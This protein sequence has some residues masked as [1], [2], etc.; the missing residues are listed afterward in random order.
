MNTIRIGT[1]GSKLALAQAYEI[2]DRLLAAHEGLAPEAIEIIAIKTTGDRIL[3]R[4]LEDIGGKGLFTK[5][6]EE[7]LLEGM[8]DIAVHSMKDVPAHYPDALVIDCTPE[9]EDPRD[10][11][12]S[13]TYP[14]LETLP[15]GAILGT[16]S[17]RRKA[18]F[19]AKRPDLHIVPF[20]GNV[21]TR[22]EKL[23]RGEAD[24]TI[25]AV[26]GLN[27]IALEQHITAIMDTNIVL[28]AVAQGALGIQRRKNDMRIASLLAPL[29]HKE[30]SLQVLAERAVLVELEGS[31]RT[32][33]AAFAEIHD[34]TL[35]LRALLASRDGSTLF[36]EERTGLVSDAEAMGKDV[37][38]ALRKKGRGIMEFL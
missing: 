6:V 27:R 16:S 31:C 23:E 8:V 14:S 3:D 20:R 21:L 17:S 9:R 7:A 38:V 4:N 19:L 13:R 37:A 32:P 5:E 28:P 22:L 36:R 34:E 18:Q 25:L 24:A 11:F 1:R 15:Q 35:R 30:T 2:R 33:L 12:I 10:A 26:A 29:N